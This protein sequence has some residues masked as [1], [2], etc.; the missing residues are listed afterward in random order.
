M[1]GKRKLRFDEGFEGSIPCQRRAGTKEMVG[2][3]QMVRK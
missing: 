1:M 3:V 2:F